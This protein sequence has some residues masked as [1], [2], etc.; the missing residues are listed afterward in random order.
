M[1]VFVGLPKNFPFCEDP[2][3][4]SEQRVFKRYVGKNSLSSEHCK[5][6]RLIMHWPEFKRSMS[7]HYQ[8]HCWQVGYNGM[9]PIDHYDGSLLHRHTRPFY[10]PLDFVRDYLGQPVPE[11]IWILLKQETVSGSGIRWA[12]C[13]SAPRPRHL[14]VPALHHLAFL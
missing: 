3:G 12:V 7:Q 6:G 1:S 4:G 8:V 10:G 2:T 5:F 11:P 14:T 9:F 13:K